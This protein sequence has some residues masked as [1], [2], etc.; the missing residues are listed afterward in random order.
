MLQQSRED[1]KRWD[2]VRGRN[3]QREEKKSQKDGN[4]P[5]QTREERRK[6]LC[7]LLCWQIGAGSS[8]RSEGGMSRLRKELFTCG[9]VAQLQDGG[10]DWVLMSFGDFVPV[11]LPAGTGTGV[12]FAG[13]LREAEEWERS[14]STVGSRRARLGSS[15]CC[16]GIPLILVCIAAR[17][18]ETRLLCAE[19]LCPE[20]SECK[21]GD[22]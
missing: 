22:N 19:A 17:P 18:S 12:C 15:P 2:G 4:A 10:S 1:G 11:H 20:S 9:E 13:W 14:S 7:S 5:P 3:K 16:L 21:Q 6:R 8:E